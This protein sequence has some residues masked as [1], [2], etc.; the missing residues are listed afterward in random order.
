MNL[1]NVENT[2]TASVQVALTSLFG[3]TTM[4]LVVLFATKSPLLRFSLP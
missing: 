3:Q 1:P 2:V 4:T